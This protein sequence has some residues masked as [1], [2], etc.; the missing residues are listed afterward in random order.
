MKRTLK[1]NTFHNSTCLGIGICAF[2]VAP[3]FAL[4]S[5]TYNVNAGAVAIIEVPN[6]PKMQITAFHYE[7]SSDDG[8]GNFQ[9]AIFAPVGCSRRAGSL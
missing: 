2:S 4:T 3:V 1:I 5:Y 8:P 9:H 7:P 6:Q